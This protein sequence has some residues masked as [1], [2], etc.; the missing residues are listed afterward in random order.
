MDVFFWC[1]LVL[2]VMDKEPLPVSG[3]LLL[4]AV[5]M[6]IV[7][8]YVGVLTTF[9]RCQTGMAKVLHHAANSFINCKVCCVVVVL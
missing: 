5:L 1:Q 3:L 9:A 8:W 2:F 4:F 6:D 7:S